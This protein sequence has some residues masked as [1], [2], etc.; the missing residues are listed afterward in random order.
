MTLAVEVAQLGDV[1]VGAVALSLDLSPAPPRSAR[2]PCRSGGR[3]QRRGS[4]GSACRLQLDRDREEPGSVD[5]RGQAMFGWCAH[6]DAARL[7]VKP[8]VGPRLSV[9][10]AR[11]SAEG[12]QIGQD[13]IA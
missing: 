13:T 1:L 6:S 8:P 5:G 7:G 11:F 3:Q 9:T 4:P 12:T 2:T 10:D